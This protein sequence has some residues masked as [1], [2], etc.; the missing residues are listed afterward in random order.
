METKQTRRHFLTTLSSAGALAV[1]GAP[2]STAAEGPPETTSIRLV[3]NDGICIAPQYVAD[4][5]LRV[6]GFTDIRHERSTPPFMGKAVGRGEV[7]MSLYF[8]G[9]IIKAVDASEPV[10]VLAGAH[11]GCFELFAHGDVRSIV[12]LKRRRI[13]IQGLGSYPHVFLASMISYVGLDPVNVPPAR[14]LHRPHSQG[15]EASRPAGPAGDTSRADHQHED[16]EGA[17]PHRAAAAARPRRRGDRVRRREFISLLGGAATW[18]LA[19]R[20]Q[21]WP[22]DRR[23]RA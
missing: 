10:T 20:A 5:L 9:E 21:Q 23:E 1:A 6:E 12:D 17:R 18:A 13:G 16:R 14:R 7:D 3:K 19:A 2:P 8:A 4:E 22:A 11:I 15:R